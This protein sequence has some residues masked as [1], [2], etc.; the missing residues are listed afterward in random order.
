MWRIM[1]L[2]NVSGLSKFYGIHHVFQ[3]VSFKVSSHDRIGIVG[4][5]GAGKTTLFRLLSS[6]EECD[7]GIISRGKEVKIAYMEQHSDYTS[8]KSAIQEVLDVFS[9]LKILEDQIEMITKQLQ[10]SA[11]DL[12]IKKHSAMSEQFI[13]L[14]GLTYKS[15]A[16]STL[17]GL[18]FSENELDLPLCHLSGGQRTRVLLAKILLSGSDL[19][20]LDEPTNHLDIQAVQWLE[21]FLIGYKGA[22]LVISHDRFFLDRI[23][24]KIFE[25]VNGH[26]DIYNGNYTDYRKQKAVRQLS[27][28]REYTRKQQEIKRIEG[29]IEQ[30]R[31]FNQERNYITI[32]SKQK[33]IDKI[34][35]ELVAPE[36]DPQEIHFTFKSCGDCANEVLVAEHISKEFKGTIL[37]RDI[38]MFIKRKD[39]I[40]LIGPNGCGKTTLL[41]ILLSMEPATVGQ[42]I[43][44][45]R[46]KVGY[47]DQTQSDL[48]M[49]KT[50]FDEISDTY[51]SMDNTSV[52]SAL[53]AFLFKGD[54][55]YKKISELSGGERARVSLVKL[56]LSQANFLI[57]DEPTNHLDIESKEILE[58]ALEKYDGTLLMVS[59]DRYFIQKFANKI[60]EIKDKKIICYEGDYSYYLEK[61][62]QTQ[63]VNV[64]KKK[65]GDNS[66]LMKKAQQAENRRRQTSIKRIEKEIEK[67]EA[68]LSVL[69]EDLEKPEVAGNY[70]I[71]IEKTN[72]ISALIEQIDALY[73]EWENMSVE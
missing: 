60:Y 63:I 15:R 12:L 73:E 27:L 66:Y 54:D 36:Q 26:L 10:N 52:R 51:P 70:V 38:N 65:P 29:I 68:D 56:I 33:Q 37:F 41:R 47:Y 57:L 72:Q 20:L 9:Q 61:S 3:D 19:L 25:M 42:I 7:A 28:E 62:A 18:G 48:T 40:F 67:A 14:G 49:E 43:I 71:L 46:V 4:V 1:L 39:R 11:N 58:N 64:K 30:Q 69:Q 17:L 8:N 21:E 44:G 2:L 34:S 55:V 35:S 6:N 45:S 24:T 16:R 13:N 53:G 32:K 22:V 5:N 50:I 23:C 59:H 31:R